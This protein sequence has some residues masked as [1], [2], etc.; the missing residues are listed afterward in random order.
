MGTGLWYLQRISSL[1]ILAYL[2]FLLF[3]YYVKPYETFAALWLTDINS[4]NMKI[5]TVFFVFSMFIHAV[6][7]LKAIEDDY[8]SERTLGFISHELGNL[9]SFFR[10]LYRFF[11]ALV[12]LVISYI[13]VFE[14]VFKG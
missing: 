8:F 4:L 7:G 12:I 1:I 5:F 3:S 9:A 14:Y 10:F 13:V 11:I 6:Q 2:A